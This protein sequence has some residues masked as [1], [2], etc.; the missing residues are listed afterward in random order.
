VVSAAVPRAARA[1]DEDALLKQMMTLNSA[2]LDDYSNG[3]FDKAKSHLLQAVSLGKKDA[4]LQTHPMMAR[5]YVHLGALYVDG[6]EDRKA[7]IGYFQKALQLKP[8]IEVTEALLTKSVE[9]AFDQAKAQAKLEIKPDTKLA[10]KNETKEP[11]KEAPRE[12]EKQAAKEPAAKPAA[13]VAVAVTK[14]SAATGA[15]SQTASPTAAKPEPAQRGAGAER[16]TEAP[17]SEAKPASTAPSTA[18]STVPTALSA[19]D[20]KALRL[21]IAKEEIAARLA[22]SKEAKA[23]AADKKRADAERDRLTKE[24]ATL[25]DSEAKERA[26]KE[27]L[28]AEKAAADKALADSRTEAQRLEKERAERDKQLAAEKDKTQKDLSALKDSEAKERAAKEKLIAEKAT[29]DKALADA[30]GEVQRLE[31][32]KADRDKQLADGAEREKHER[33]AKEKLLAEKQAIESR[34]KARQAGEEAARLQ[35]ARLAE[36]P[37]LPAHF[38]EPIHCTIPD[39]AEPDAELFVHCLAKPGLGAKDMAIYY[40]ASNSTHFNSLGMRA[41]KKG[42]QSAII[43]ASQV[44]GKVLQYYVELRDARGELA[45]SNGKPSSPNILSLRRG[46]PAGVARS[47]GGTGERK[48]AVLIRKR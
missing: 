7:G 14:P 10:A 4:D 23:A 39:E 40:R 13:A 29:T 27:K 44:T 2:A 15:A 6:F 34:E 12:P 20:E 21:A 5:T 3:D 46:A 16:V 42:W 31:K 43:P 17:K 32:E 1:A 47:S 24:L 18:P 8:D 45:A 11:T 26:A 22:A 38:S 37:E 25:K 48:E 28:V 35:R 36:G 33:E 19:K 9:A 30:R 41:S